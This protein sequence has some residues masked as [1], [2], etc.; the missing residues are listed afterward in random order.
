MTTTRKV[1]V[2]LA[3]AAHV[4]LLASSR[5]RARSP[6]WLVTRLW[7]STLA[8][9][10]HELWTALPS[11]DSPDL[12]PLTPYLP[13]EVYADLHSASD[14]YDRS[15]G[16][17]VSVLVTGLDHNRRAHLWSTPLPPEPTPAPMEA[18]P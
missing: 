2:R 4:T 13:P 7:A 10:R 6:G 11:P 3:P 8:R 5:T 14:H 1:T 12:T 18:H 17:L 16:W 9:E 15:M